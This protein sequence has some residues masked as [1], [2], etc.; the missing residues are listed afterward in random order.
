MFILWDKNP[1]AFSPH[2]A[3]CISVSRLLLT[4]FRLLFHEFAIKTP[5]TLLVQNLY[6]SWLFSDT[7]WDKK[8]ARQSW[9]SFSCFYLRR[10]AKGD[11]WELVPK[12]QW[13]QKKHQPRALLCLYTASWNTGSLQRL[14]KRWVPDGHRFVRFHSSQHIFISWNWWPRGRML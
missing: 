3:T 4:F 1:Q 7:F 5:F 10:E 14:G 9:V 12:K 2:V 8:L 6:L 11:I 13:A